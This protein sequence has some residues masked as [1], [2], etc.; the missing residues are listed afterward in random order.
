M[1]MKLQH[2]TVTLVPSLLKKGHTHKHTNELLLH[3]LNNNATCNCIL[4][5]ELD[6]IKVFL[7]G[8]WRGKEA[9][10]DL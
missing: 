1:Y 2:I 4:E 5:K 6:L 10:C 9:L 7:R 3:Y 8:Y